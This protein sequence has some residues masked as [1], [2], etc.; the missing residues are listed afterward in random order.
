MVGRIVSTEE[1]G[2]GEIVVPLAF[3]HGPRGRV[4]CAETDLLVGGAERIGWKATPRE[5]RAE[6][7]AGESPGRSEARAAGPVRSTGWA[8]SYELGTGPCLGFA[9]LADPADRK[10]VAAT[11]R[12]VEGWAR[13]LRTRLLVTTETGPL[14]GGARDLLAAVR[15]A[16]H[17]TEGLPGGPAGRVGESAAG[18]RV[19]VA[20]TEGCG[21]MLTDELRRYGARPTADAGPARPGDLLIVGPLPPAPE[22]RA[23]AAA[24]G[25]V[26]VD[27]VC[28]RHHAA[29]GEIARLAGQ[30]E[31]VVL[32]A[33]R[34]TAAAERLAEGG[35]R[36]GAEPGAAPGAEPGPRSGLMPGRGPGSVSGLASGS[37][38]E[39]GARSV[40]GLV[41]KSG[42]EA[43]AGLLSG[44]GSGSESGVP[45]GPVSGAEPGARSGVPSEGRPRS[46]PPPEPPSGAASGADSSPVAWTV[47]APE[48]ADVPDPARV[49]FALVPG[50]PLRPALAVGEGLRARFG[51]VIPQAPRTYCYE[52]DDRRD[53]VRCVAALVDLLLVAACPG[54]PEAAEVASWAPRGTRVRT[55][56]SVRDLDPGWLRSAG[57]VGVVETVHAPRTLAGRLL[58]ALRKLGPSDTVRRSVVTRRTGAD[59][60]APGPPRD[61]PE[62]LGGGPE[63]AFSARPFSL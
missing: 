24:P 43:R 1:C 41:S 54:D 49:G 26:V 21:R 5:M 45:S 31:H 40:S 18:R 48:E 53:T 8:V 28:E 58:A 62:A 34:P 25:A 17:A 55:V 33:P 63:S 14:C 19:L 38:S 61:R 56:T 23:R 20:G 7:F 42:P 22:D 44:S 15:S 50:Q 39:P 30:G 35:S 2:P 57:A 4:T 52:A 9:A 11:R 3:P 10:A 6:A 47:S 29:A 60:S 36:G 12:L 37:G 59:E 27:A 46:G 32:A 51:H 13:A 16:E